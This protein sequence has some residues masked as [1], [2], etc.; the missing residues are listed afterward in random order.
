MVTQWKV[1]PSQFLVI[2]VN[3]ILT[4]ALLTWFVLVTRRFGQIF[5]Q[6]RAK[7]LSRQR[8]LVAWLPHISAQRL[9]QRTFVRW[10]SRHMIAQSKALQMALAARKWSLRSLSKHFKVHF[11]R[12]LLVTPWKYTVCDVFLI[13]DLEIFVRP[14]SCSGILESVTPK[15]KIFYFVGGTA[16]T[17]IAVLT[18]VS[19]IFLFSYFFN[20]ISCLFDLI[21]QIFFSHNFKL[22]GSSILCF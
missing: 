20:F 17:T 10:K 5:L 12:A 6:T 8:F 7:T 3:L 15:E 14:C 13:T 16:S 22:S 21:F 18:T 9:V 11:N 2:G 1:L 19:F 4:V